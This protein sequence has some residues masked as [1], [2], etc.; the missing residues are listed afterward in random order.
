MKKTVFLLLVI[1]FASAYALINKSNQNQDEESYATVHKAMKDRLSLEKLTGAEKF[2]AYHDLIKSS[3]EGHSGSYQSGYISEEYKHAKKRALTNNTSQSRQAVE[4]EERGPG[5]VSG[6]CRTVWVD[7]SDSS[8][9]TWFLGSAQGGVWKTT[10][11]GQ[12]YELKTPDVPHLGTAAIMGCT[13]APN[14]IYAGS[15]EGFN[16]ISPAGAGVF[17][18]TDGGETWEVLGSTVSNQAF[19]NIF[20]IAVSHDDPD[21]VYVATKNDNTLEDTEGFVMRSKDGGE[22]WEE[23]LFH[24]DAVSHIAM[25]PTDSNILFAGLNQEGL[26]KT[27]DGGFYD[28]DRI[29]GSDLCF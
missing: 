1:G 29:R 22:T 7:P 28:P 13:S 11:A 27:T 20:R 5:N 8:G 21:V 15:G 10:N 23:V 18:S 24:F 3:P 14:V 6:R 17:K 26:L 2:V 9:N 4:W 12:S 25:H 19:A 16:F